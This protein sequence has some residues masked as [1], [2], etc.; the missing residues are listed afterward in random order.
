MVSSPPTRR[1]PVMF[2]ESV[3]FDLLPDTLAETTC[4]PQPE[5][6]FGTAFDIRLPALCCWRTTRPFT[7]P[8]GEPPALFGLRVAIL[9]EDEMVPGAPG[10][11]F[12]L[13]LLGCF[14]TGDCCFFLLLPFFFDFGLF[15][16]TAKRRDTVAVGASLDD[17]NV[18]DLPNSASK[19]GPAE[20]C[21]WADQE[22]A[23]VAVW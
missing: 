20:R 12:P 2:A 11:F 4:V 13:E 3:L 5:Q 15:A 23:A 17:R 9:L 10:C 8:G 18:Y 21:C 19:K 1:V 16:A 7:P 22:N 6:S 14:C